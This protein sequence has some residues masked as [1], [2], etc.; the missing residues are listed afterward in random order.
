VLLEAVVKTARSD[1]EKRKGILKEEMFASVQRAAQQLEVLG[2]RVTLKAVS[3]VTGL[4]SYHLKKNSQVVALLNQYSLEYPRL[5]ERQTRQRED[6]LVVEV[7]EA[8]RQLE[9]LGE[10]VSHVAIYKITGLKR[11]ELIMHPRVWEVLQSSVEA[12][13]QQRKKKQEDEFV[14]K[15][16][17]AFDQLEALGELVTRFNICQK[18]GVPY[19]FLFKYP[20]AVSYLRRRIAEAKR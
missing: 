1:R 11:E 18:M 9:Q 12:S 14:A 5:M 19:S 20:E 10:T 16:M 3:E 13:R 6:G 7:E 17:A 4:H 2:Q 15:V 8:I